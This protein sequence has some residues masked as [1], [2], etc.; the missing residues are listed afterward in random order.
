M[1]ATSVAAVTTKYLFGMYNGMVDN[2]VGMRN[3]SFVLGILQVYGHAHVQSH[4]SLGMD[5][6]LL[7]MNDSS[8]YFDLHVQDPITEIPNMTNNGYFCYSML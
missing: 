1:T 8:E 2:D 6:I 4:M 7:C 3:F 5:C